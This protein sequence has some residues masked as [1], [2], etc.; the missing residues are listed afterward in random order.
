M[1]PTV[2]R[3]ETIAAAISGTSNSR[4]RH[5]RA[6][7]AC[8]RTDPVADLRQ[9]PRRRP[10]TAGSESD[11]LVGRLRRLPR[12]R[13]AGCDA[14]ARVELCVLN[15]LRH[16]RTRSGLENRSSSFAPWLPDP[17][18]T[19]PGAPLSSRCVARS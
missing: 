16:G 4:S 8:S 12:R 2:V 18:K 1:M 19:V 14:I 11:V 13:R 15:A 17:V 9:P 7:G 5:A 3:I 6:P 10:S